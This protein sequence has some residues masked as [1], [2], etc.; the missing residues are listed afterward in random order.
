MGDVLKV[1]VVDDQQEDSQ[2]LADYL[3]QFEKEHQLQIQID[4]Y[5]ASF[6]FLE[7]YQGNYAGK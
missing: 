3:Q 7:K 4:V 1:A 5:N 6:E 2:R